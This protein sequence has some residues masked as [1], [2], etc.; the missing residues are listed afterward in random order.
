MDAERQL[1]IGGAP[2][3]IESWVRTLSEPAAEGW[4][5]GT[6]IERKVKLHRDAG[7]PICLVWSGEGRH[8]RTA[9][10][11]RPVSDSEVAVTSVVPI[12]RKEL[13]PDERRAAL[14]AF[15]TALVMPNGTDLV[16]EEKSSAVELSDEVSPRATVYFRTFARTANK[17]LLHSG[18]DLPRWY[19]FLIQLHRDGATP[20]RDALE[21]ALK[22]EAF[23]PEA[24]TQL[25]DA[26]EH[27]EDLLLR[28][29]AFG[30]RE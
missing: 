18:L 3:A 6:E 26:Y 30:G 19:D 28:Y 14:D 8:P 12:D 4:S 25:L 2:P 27:S 29:D 17:T 24:I 22:N 23:S 13:A 11:L 5:R 15:R 21:A 10:F 9:L 16:V 20:P 1:T 7:W